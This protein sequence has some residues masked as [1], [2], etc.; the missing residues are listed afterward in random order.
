[1]KQFFCTVKDVINFLYMCIEKICDC[2]RLHAFLAG[3]FISHRIYSPKRTVSHVSPYKP[4]KVNTRSDLFLF[5]QE[6][7]T[8]EKALVLVVLWTVI[9]L[10]RAQLLSKIM[11]C[12]KDVC[13][14]SHLLGLFNVFILF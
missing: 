7:K 5:V 14:R 10:L 9:C 8:M 11:F 13:K 12:G 2:S 6:N 4:N 3:P 1:M